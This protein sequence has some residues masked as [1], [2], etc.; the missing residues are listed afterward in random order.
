MVFVCLFYSCC[1]LLLG[2]FVVF[3][4]FFFFLGGG[5]RVRSFVCFLGEF[6]GGFFIYKFK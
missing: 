3:V 6:L 2:F 5:G 4:G 1:W